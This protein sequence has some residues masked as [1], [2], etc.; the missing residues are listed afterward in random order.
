M[1][2][3]CDDILYVLAIWRDTSFSFIFIEF[4][5]QEWIEKYEVNRI[6]GGLLSP[7]FATSSYRKI[8][9]HTTSPFL[10][11][12]GSKP[13]RASVQLATD[14]VWNEEKLCK[15]KVFTVPY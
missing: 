7:A 15:D 1:S 8:A 5:Q 9:Q 14:L 11:G 4:E 3:R 12:D 10:L 2:F 13:N 6:R